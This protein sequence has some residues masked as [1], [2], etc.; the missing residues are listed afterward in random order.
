MAKKF[1]REKVLFF[2]AG[3]SATEKEDAT[4]EKFIRDGFE[5]CF[6]KASKGGENDPI[7]NFE[8]VAGAVPKQYKEAS[9]IKGDTTKDGPREAGGSDTPNAEKGKQGEATQAP[10]TAVPAT[11][12]AKQSKDG[13]KP[14]T[15]WKPNA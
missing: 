3:P 4:A 1:K 7:E 9:K 5:V 14:G 11:E 2:L 15:G 8:H 12:P 10:Q 6:R 13:N